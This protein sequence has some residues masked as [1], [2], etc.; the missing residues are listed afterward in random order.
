ME[1][2]TISIHFSW[3]NPQNKWWFNIAKPFSTPLQLREL[4]AS[5]SACCAGK[6]WI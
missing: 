3:E 5:A 1:K 2:N 4:R 6:I